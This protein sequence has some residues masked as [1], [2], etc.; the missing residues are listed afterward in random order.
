M[1]SR[2][3]SWLR[4]TIVGAYPKP[5]RQRFKEAR[6][7]LARKPSQVDR[8]QYLRFLTHPR[9]RRVSWDAVGVYDHLL[10]ADVGVIPVER[11]AAEGGKIGIWAI[12]SE[13]RLTLKMATALPVVAAPVPAYLPVIR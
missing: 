7:A 6:W 5:V 3:P 4:V 12:K 13:N 1:I 11:A 2:V 9:I 8:L 10:S